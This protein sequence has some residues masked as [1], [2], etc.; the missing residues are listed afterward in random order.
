MDP[1]RGKKEMS[2]P[3]LQ[4]H[5]ALFDVHVP[6]HINLSPV[7]SFIKEYKPTHFIIGGDYLNL[8]WASHWNEKEFKYIGLEKLRG[9]LNKELE[10]GREVLKELTAAL[11]KDC[12]KYYIPGNHEEWLY[13]A[14]MTYPA[15]AGAATL[16]VETM[17]FKSDLAEIRKQVIADLLVQHL[18]T[19]KLG[20][21]M[22]T[23]G[24]ELNLGKLTYIH[25]HQVSGVAAMR[26]KYPA[27]SV[28]CGHHHTEHTE[29]L[30][31]SGEQKNTN[32]YTVVPCLCHLS[33]GYLQDG[34]TRWTNGFWV[35]D[36]LPNGNFSGRVVKVV[37]NYVLSN[38]KVYT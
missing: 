2:S 35:A 5:L 38:G 23:Y 21:K 15:L 31:N 26:R 25:G 17:T 14:C 20:F 33:P 27:R 19:D 3:K 29:L 22:L 18:G 9:M 16:G 8:E 10:A 7:I 32:Q 6:H 34:S 28:V 36:V 4:K 1:Q 24:K 30:H 37:D 11:P 12:D 13:W